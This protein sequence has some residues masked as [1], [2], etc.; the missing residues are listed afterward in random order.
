MQYLLIYITTPS[1]EVA[2][3]L[4][5]TLVQERLAACANVFDGA[6]SYYWWDNAVQNTRESLCL[7]KTTAELFPALE[8]R[9]RA[10]HP[11][12]VPC[13]VAL[14]LVAGHTSFLDWIS[15]ETA[16]EAVKH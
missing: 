5:Q 6:E 10:L 7:C 12:D 4:A 15:R 11:Y 1:M 3:L 13:I 16:Q 9:V 14:P 2:R 8:G